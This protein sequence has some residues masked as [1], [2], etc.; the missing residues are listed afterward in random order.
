MMF[1]YTGKLEKIQKLHCVLQ[2]QSTS[3]QAQTGVRKYIANVANVSTMVEEEARAAA[4][5]TLS[6][7]RVSKTPACHCMRAADKSRLASWR[8]HFGCI[9]FASRCKR[10]APWPHLKVG[11]RRLLAQI[12]KRAARSKSLV[13]RSAAHRHF[14]LQRKRG[15]VWALRNTL[16]LTSPGASGMD[17]SGHTLQ[18]SN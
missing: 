9:D 16:V 4:N 14:G 3:K 17:S 1:S 5:R 6:Q 8:R 10:S 15:G 13:Q 7:P 18:Y 11:R 2:K 12:L